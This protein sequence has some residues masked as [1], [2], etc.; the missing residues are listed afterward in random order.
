MKVALIVSP[1]PLEESPAP[2]LGLCYAA[3]AFESA[4]VEVKIFDYLVRGYTPEKLYS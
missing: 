1:Y 2:P 3:A 4:G